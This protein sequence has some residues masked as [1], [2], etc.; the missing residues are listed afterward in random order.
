MA[1]D[2]VPPLFSASEMNLLV[3]HY[4]KESGFHHACFALRYEARLDDLPVAHEPVVQPGQLLRYVQKGLLY[5]LSLI[6][7]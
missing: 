1:A 3:Y 7:I 5:A 2:A 6:H 4:L